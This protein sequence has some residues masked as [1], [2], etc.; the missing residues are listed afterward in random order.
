MTCKTCGIRLTPFASGDCGRHWTRPEQ[1]ARE[2]RIFPVS[3]WVRK[4]Q[5]SDLPAK[6]LTR[7]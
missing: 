3:P 5:T 1:P 4:A 6:D 2:Q 7:R